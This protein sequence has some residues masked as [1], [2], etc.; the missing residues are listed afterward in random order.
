MNNYAQR[1]I[2][3]FYKIKGQIAEGGQAHVKK[4]WHR[5]TMRK[6]AVKIYPIKKLTPEGFKQVKY[7]I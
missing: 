3:T 1:D 6:V 2:T 7:E 4:A 5:K